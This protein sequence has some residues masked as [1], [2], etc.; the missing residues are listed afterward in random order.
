MRLGM[1]IAKMNVSIDSGLTYLLL[2]VLRL[3][4]A[5]QAF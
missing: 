5:W 2:Q 3:V 4:H 1:R